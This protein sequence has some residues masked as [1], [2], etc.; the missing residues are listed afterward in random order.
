[1]RIVIGFG[2]KHF[3]KPEH[4]GHRRSKLVRNV[5]QKL[6]LA[7]V[8]HLG[9]LFT[10]LQLVFAP[11]K[12]LDGVFQTLTCRHQTGDVALN[13]DVMGDATFAV[14]NRRQFQLVV[15]RP[16]VFGVV[17][18]DFV[19]ILAAFDRP[20]DALNDFRIGVGTLQKPT[21]APHHFFGWIPGDGFKALVDIHDRNIGL[22]DIGDDDSVACRFDRERLQPHLLFD[23]DA[24]PDVADQRKD[25][26]LIVEPRRRQY[27]FD[28]Q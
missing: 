25:V 14:G 28:R 3:G 12:L 26:A 24:V 15:K 20:T 5:R 27:E 8:G 16:P 13:A 19:R 6:G 23:A 11:S 22:A 21:I 17:Q 4:R 10:H 9:G 18:K 2:A 1:M 7:A